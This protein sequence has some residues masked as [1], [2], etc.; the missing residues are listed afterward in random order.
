MRYRRDR[1]RGAAWRFQPRLRAQST[2]QQLRDK[3]AELDRI[4]QER[5]DLQDG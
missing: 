1:S 3:Q 5:D 2:E 4:R